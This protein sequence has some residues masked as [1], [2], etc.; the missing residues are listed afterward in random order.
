MTDS[1]KFREVTK[2]N[3]KKFW[4]VAAGLEM[5]PQSLYN[6]LGNTCEFTQT[7]MRKFREIFPD[8]DDAEFKAIFFAEQFSA[9]VNE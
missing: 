8:V 4:E 1:T 9:D 6:K 7:E 5:S 3:G 2:R